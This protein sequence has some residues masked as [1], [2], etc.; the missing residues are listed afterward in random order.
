MT[1]RTIKRVIP[2]LETSDGAGVRIRRSL[3]QTQ[4]VRMDPFL[5]LDEF[6]SDQPQDY[7]AGFPAHPHRGFET[8]TYMIEGHMLHED[9]LGNRGNLRN[10]G[11]QWMTAGR[12]IVHSEMP[13]QE[14]GMMR[15]FQLWLNLPAAEKMKAAGYRDIQ[16]EDIPR[17]AL[18]GGEVR[19]IAG[20]LC[21]DGQ[22]RQGA[23]SGGSTEPLYADLHLGAGGT[24]ALPV[25]AHLNAMVYLY[26][27]SASI[28][29]QELTRS[30]ATLLETGDRLVVEAGPQGA[31]LLLIGGRPIGEPVV[32][33][34]PFVM[35]SRE[36]IE[37]TLR[38]Y[39]SGRL[40]A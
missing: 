16:P 23:V 28:C 36:E 4:L 6:G 20:E 13:Q 25:A 29:G 7:I 34:G 26:E 33:Y 24:L 14:E 18:D 15:G 5:M 10:G 9:H 11:V 35:N 32:Q 17:I 31:Q 19:L 8:V 22:L 1:E 38:D 30:A 40:T 12:G 27:G 21:L 3:G 37:Q 2:A 39:Q